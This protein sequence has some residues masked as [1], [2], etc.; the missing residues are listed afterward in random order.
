MAK[1][2]WSMSRVGGRRH[3]ID[4]V[5]RAE[6]GHRIGE[7]S[8][9]KVRYDILVEA[10]G[11]WNAMSRFRDDRRRNKNYTYGDQWQDQICVDGEYMTEEQYILRQGNVPL[12]NNL[13]RK[14]V[15]SVMG[16]YEKQ[17]IEPTVTT[18]DRGEQQLGEVVNTVLQYVMHLNHMKELYAR[19][20]EEY[21]IS[22]LVV[23][24]KWYGWG[25]VGRGRLDCWTE[26]VQP[27]N[28]FIDGDMRDFRGW[29]CG[30]VGEIHD[31]SF[32][33]LAHKFAKSDSDYQ[34]LSEVYRHAM[35][36]D[37]L[38]SAYQQ[39]G[40]PLHGDFDFLAPMDT[41]RCRV[42][43]VWKK[44]SKPRY[45]CHDFNEGTV[46]KIEEEDYDKMV[47]EE[48]RRRLLEGFA[49]GLEEEDIPLIE[50]TW[51]VDSYWHYYYLS[52]LG[53]VLDEGESPYDHGSHPY[54]FKAYPFIDGEI[55][56]FVSDFVD[57]QRYTNRLITMYDWIMRSS[58]KG[59]L[60]FPE[61]CLPVGMSVEEVA[62]TW[63]RM[64]GLIMIKQPKT[65]TALPQQ[66]ANN[67]TNIGIS[68][69]LR[70][71]LNLFEDISGVTGALQGKPGFAGMSA[72]LYNQQT[73]NATTTLVDL[74]NSFGEFMKDAAMKDVSNIQQFYDDD[75][76]FR[77]VGTDFL[78]A[79]EM[80]DITGWGDIESDISMTEGTETPAYR[81][82]MNDFLMQLYEKQAISLEM[83]LENGSFP[84]ADKLLQSVRAEMEKAQAQQ[85]EA[86]PMQ[87]QGQEAGATGETLNIEQ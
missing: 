24:R 48:N 84:W 77:I 60:I 57:Q 10:Q 18:R 47:V 59:V 64:D 30:M 39:F 78:D 44:E 86:M 25:G 67:C 35:D 82:I 14:M 31:M 15:R 61:E 27:G 4:S 53:H 68:E 29:D 73:Q 28:F 52:P 40:Y 13:I 16:V 17:G 3:E 46:Y 58:A 36:R 69:L 41:T 75:R 43:E 54:V 21:L 85:Q 8:G 37:Y 42:I 72:S 11:Y 65:G 51:M 55:H 23:H 63:S 80:A 5:K 26:Y 56:S 81:M 87:A 49:Q 50:A 9:F 6:I 62:D 32:Q 33:T 76:V 2:L 7:D 45:R 83:L 19:S 74:L 38:G 66:I 12:K 34:K 1:K 70:I 20:L 22:G 79:Y 71:Q